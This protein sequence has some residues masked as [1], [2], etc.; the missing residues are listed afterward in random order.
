MIRLIAALMLLIALGAEVRAEA[1]TVRPKLKELVT[2]TSEVVRIGDLVENAGDAADTPVFRAP[3]LGQ[4]GSVPAA[5]V[6]EAM[7]SKGVDG[8]DTD[9]LSEVVVTRLSR[10]ITGDELKERIARAISGQFGYGSADNLSVILDR[11]LRLLHVEATATGDL[12][13]TRMNV[14]P[15]TGRFDVGFELPGSMAARRASLRFTGTVTELAPAVTLARSLRSGE[16][17][18]A[19]DLVIE[20]R[21]KHDIG[22][23][24]ISSDQAV[25]FAAKAALRGGQMLRAGDLVKAQLVQRNEAVTIVYEVPGVTLTLRGKASEG[26][27]E[28]DVISVLNMQTNRTLQG[29]VIGPGRIAVGAVRLATTAAAVT[30][31]AAV[32]AADDNS[33]QHTE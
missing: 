19:S 25:G 16:V 32:T 4:T 15:R 31:T 17:V 23:D 13:V 30:T 3:D 21:P 8:L 18:K 12:V 11:A 2:V 1:P 5:R 29:T 9:G 20:K 26:G 28:G 27:A 10:A 6:T 22:P 24:A 14:E 7:R 33:S